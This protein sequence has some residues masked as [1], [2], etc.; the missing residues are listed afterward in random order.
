LFIYLI[1]YIALFVP[2]ESTAAPDID[3]L[4]LS[5]EEWL[6]SFILNVIIKDVIRDIPEY[7][8]MDIPSKKGGPRNI[9]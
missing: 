4:L 6:E 7:I 2:D 5:K 9:N 3:R 1:I 8:S